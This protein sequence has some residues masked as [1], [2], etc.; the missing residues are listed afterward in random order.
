MAYKDFVND[1]N[2]GLLKDVLLFYGAE[3]FLMEWAVENNSL[4]WPTLDISYL[5]F[6]ENHFYIWL[7]NVFAVTAVVEIFFN[8]V[9]L[10]KTPSL[11]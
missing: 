11:R 5:F 1:K 8:T 7:L 6:D 10:Y 9:F 2:K 3:D 4:F